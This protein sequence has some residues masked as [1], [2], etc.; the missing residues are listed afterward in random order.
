MRTV[1][2]DKDPMVVYVPKIVRNERIVGKMVK[3]P[4]AQYIEWADSLKQFIK[5]Q[6]EMEE[7][8]R[9]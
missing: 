4:E 1:D 2:I 3:I 6:E 7:F 9:G 5:C 8:Y